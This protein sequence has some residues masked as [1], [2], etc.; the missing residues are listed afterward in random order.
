M[1]I[2]VARSCVYFASLVGFFSSFLDCYVRRRKF[3]Q[4]KCARAYSKRERTWND[5]RKEKRMDRCTDALDIDACEEECSCWA[6][7][8]RKHLLEQK[9]FD[10]NWA[11]FCF[12][13]RKATNI[14]MRLHQRKSSRNKFDSFVNSIFVQSSISAS[15]IALDHVHQRQVLLLQP[16][17]GG[18]LYV[19][20]FFT[21]RI[22]FLLALQVTSNQ[23]NA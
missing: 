17:T 6:L 13:F 21:N 11:T 4:R 2:R 22:G 20:C 23:L 7:A 14:W 3:R 19:F 5:E 18:V 12:I 9:S 10:R 15:F 8:I 1:N 16:A